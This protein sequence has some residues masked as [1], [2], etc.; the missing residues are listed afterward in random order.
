MTNAEFKAK[1]LEALRSGEF[2]QTT[3]TLRAG[4]SYCCLGVACEVARREGLVKAEWVKGTPVNPYIN[5][6]TFYFDE[7]SGALP[8]SVSGYLTNED[9]P[10][11]KVT[12]SDDD[13]EYSGRTLS[14]LN[15]SGMTF[16]EIADIIEKDINV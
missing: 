15:D 11:T 1:W 13:C 8:P 14:A 12:A 3:G 10:V 4:D 9:D 7:A 6:D 5:Q 2:K 16:L